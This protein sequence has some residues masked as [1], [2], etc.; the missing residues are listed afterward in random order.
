[1]NTKLY[2]IPKEVFGADIENLKQVQGDFFK[3]VYRLLISKERGPRL[4]L[5]LRY[6][7]GEVHASA[8]LQLP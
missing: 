3:K 7:Q 5:S 8:G 4:Y 1:M 2:D 6:R